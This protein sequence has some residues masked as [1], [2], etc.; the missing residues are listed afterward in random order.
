MDGAGA[1]FQA[2]TDCVQG[3]IELTLLALLEQAAHD[4]PEVVFGDVEIFALAK[5]DVLVHHAQT[6][7]GAHVGAD[8]SFGHANL[9]D[10]FIQRERLGGKVQRPI[11]GTHGFGKAPELADAAHALNKMLAGGKEF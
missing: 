1:H 10:Q 11:N 9:L 5:L 6:L 8:R 3:V 7:Q 4:L 2:F